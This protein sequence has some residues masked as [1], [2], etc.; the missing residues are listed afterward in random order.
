MKIDTK[1]IV[2]QSEKFALNIA[3]Q[4]SRI[5]LNHSAKSLFI[6]QNLEI[7]QP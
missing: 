5:R 4:I 7:E 6:P 1:D 2:K 3:D